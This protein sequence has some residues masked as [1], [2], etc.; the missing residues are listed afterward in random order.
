MRRWLIGLAFAA[1]LLGLGTY[2]GAYALLYDE[3]P[4]QT[5][6]G[7]AALVLRQALDHP[8]SSADATVRP[9]VAHDS[10]CRS[11]ARTAGQ[12]IA[13][14]SLQNL[15][16]TSHILGAER[17]MQIYLPPDYAAGHGRYPVL[18]LL[19]GAPGQ[20]DDWSRAAGIDKTLDA[21]ISVGR[22]PPLIAVLPDGNGGLLGDTEWANGTLSG[23]QAE[24]YVTKE[25]VPWV[26]AQ[27]RTCAD[28]DHRLIAGL[29]TGGFG[30]V[31][32]ALHHPDMFHYVA[33]LSGNY[34]AARTWTGKDVWGGD[35]QLKA[36]NSPLAYAAR[37]TGLSR[38]HIYLTAGA[39]EKDG[40]LQQTQ[41]LA[42]LLQKLKVPHRLEVFQ[43]THSW[44]FWR[45]HVVD[46]LD[47]L[48]Q[49]LANPQQGLS[50]A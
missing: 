17:P 22:V 23:V 1:P 42:A 20:Y 6:G 8:A 10:G 13:H 44:S 5:S 47:Y 31:N 3:L 21:L 32:I 50:A 29:S 33:G 2:L 15:S 40:T 30:A 34:L 36:Y 24:D 25:I 28:A 41:Q 4:W 12:P 43:G 37:A 11:A 49:E 39:S 38:L 48:G 27:Y 19:H 18:Y 9:A 46:A 45:T 16:F 14:G 7:E 26:D 35:A